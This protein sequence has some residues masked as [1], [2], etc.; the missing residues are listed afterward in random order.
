M[1]SADKIFRDIR[2]Y[3]YSNTKISSYMQ[4]YIYMCV[5][6]YIYIYILYIY[7]PMMKSWCCLSHRTTLVNRQ[8]SV[9]LPG[10]ASA[11]PDPN[12]LVQITSTTQLEGTLPGSAPEQITSKG[13]LCKTAVIRIKFKKRIYIFQVNAK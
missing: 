5:Y 8:A 4:V 10:S 3:N 12:P 6:I 9:I 11:L 2:G 13:R 1:A 7:I